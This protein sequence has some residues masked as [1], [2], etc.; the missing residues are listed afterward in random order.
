MGLTAVGEEGEELQG[1]VALEG[2]SSRSRRRSKTGLDL[3]MA[4]TYTHTNTNSAQLGEPVAGRQAGRQA[5]S[6]EPA[7]QDTRP[8][9]SPYRGARG[10]AG[11]WVDEPV[12]VVKHDGAP[13]VE[14]W[15][16]WSGRWGGRRVQAMHGEFEQ[17]REARQDPPGDRP[18][19]LHCRHAGA[20]LGGWRPHT[21]AGQPRCVPR[22]R[23]KQAGACAASAHC[24]H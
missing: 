24:C 20:P 2:C 22:R 6:P 7:S 16:G 17:S 4:H 19:R 15:R 3:G 14:G 10:F 8:T 1:W 18:R 9:P 13:A 11:L 5:G 23:E 12:L 21:A